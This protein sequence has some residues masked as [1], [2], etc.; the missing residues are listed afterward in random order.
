VGASFVFRQTI[1]YFLH[2][3]HGSR[4]DARPRPGARANTMN[5]ACL[6]AHLCSKR[7]TK[8]NKIEGSY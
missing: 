2:S 7:K 3:A 8:T 4:T 6:L 1:S 5:I